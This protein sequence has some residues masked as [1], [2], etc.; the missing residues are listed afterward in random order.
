[1]SQT[2]STSAKGLYSRL[3]TDRQPYLS[4]A[5]DAAKLTIPSLMPEDGHGSTSK[6]KTPYQSLGARGINNLSS[7]LLMALMPPNAPF[8][9]LRVDDPEI[10][11][12]AEA[13][14]AT[15]ELEKALGKIE[16]SVMT[17]IEKSAIRVSVGETLK[18]LIVAGNA[19]LYIKPQ[20][21]AKVFKLDQYVVQRD[22]AGN[23]LEI[24]VKESISYV[25]LPDEVKK[26][27]ELKDAN[28]SSKKEKVDLY[29][30]I[31]Y[32]GDGWKVHQEIHDMVVPG[33]EG[34][35]P[36]GKTPWIPLRFTQIDGE[37]YGRGYVEEFYGDLWSMEKLTKAVVEGS[38]AAARILFLV[39]P[40]GTT[41]ARTL[42]KAPNGAIRNGS[43][44]DVSVL[45]MDKQ[46]DFSIAYQTIGSL[47]ERL[48]YAFL[49]NSAI[50]RDAERVTAEEIRYMANELEAALGGVYSILSQEFQLPLVM[51]LMYVLED[52]GEIPTLPEG[53]VS[54][55]IT[56][57]VE[58]L[59]RGHDLEK[60]DMF[61]KGMMDA[62]PPEV[63]AQYINFS[64]YITRRGTALGI[65]TNGLV[66]SQQE[67]QQEQAAAQKAQQQQMMQQQATEQGM[68]TVGNIAEKGA[69]SNEQ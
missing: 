69:P 17:E 18:Q 29:T 61:L 41:E 32:T 8:F 35:Y 20:G 68:K 21:G 33:S 15:A 54:P 44:A 9:R 53:S 5:R 38:A 52:K 30:R 16:R 4:R 56:T 10:E 22:P 43:A 57:G 62:V 12:A 27:I 47:Q 31:T 48:S 45:Q 36:E 19:L 14:E 67:V 37:D 63:L 3:E 51:R 1:M 66:K 13:T 64:D 46:A 23:A 24:V 6:L 50:Q 58:A 59:G 25:T 2:P 40:N 7:K 60:L 55:S 65:D 26:A 11:E 42:A 28:N 49:L 34:Q 39:N